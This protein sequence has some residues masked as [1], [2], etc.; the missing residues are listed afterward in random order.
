M[1]E[2][3]TL[4][5]ASGVS[6]LLPGP[7]SEP[8]TPEAFARFDLRVGQVITAARVPRKEKLLDLAV[9]VGDEEGPRRVIAALA[10]SFSPEELAGQRVVVVCNVTRDFGRG[11]VSDGILLAAGPTE[12]MALVTVV[13]DL[14]PGAEVK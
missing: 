3:T 10:L 13:E 8:V 9:D 12:G 2:H 7:P 5:S 1:L 6:A 14:P 11:L 4:T